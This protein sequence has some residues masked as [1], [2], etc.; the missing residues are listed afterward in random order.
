MAATLRL[1]RLEKPRP[2]MVSEMTWAQRS[3]LLALMAL[4]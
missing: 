4:T 3:T 1:L 2:T